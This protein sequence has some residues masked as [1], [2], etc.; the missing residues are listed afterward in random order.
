MWVVVEMH[1]CIIF[2]FSWQC[3]SVFSG[4]A[5][6]LLPANFYW[7]SFVAVIRSSVRHG[8]FY[9]KLMCQYMQESCKCSSVS[10]S[11]SKKTNNFCTTIVRWLCFQIVLQCKECAFPLM[12][13]ATSPVCAKF[14]NCQDCAKKANT[15]MQSKTCDCTMND[16]WRRMYMYHA[17]LHSPTKQFCVA[18]IWKKELWNNGYKQCF[19]LSDSSHNE[20]NT[21]AKFS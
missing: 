6:G 21:V 4:N 5:H 11:I 8:F 20:I 3:I 19:Y 17:G 1:A 10:S 2:S 14:I 7:S 18:T 15:T 16:E 12:V 13:W 9:R